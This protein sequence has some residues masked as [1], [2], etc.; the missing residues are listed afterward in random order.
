MIVLV[1]E[2][3][4]TYLIHYYGFFEFINDVNIDDG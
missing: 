3:F 2:Q 1:I 4:I